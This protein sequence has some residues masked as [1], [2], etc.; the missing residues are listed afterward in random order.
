MKID[1]NGAY[2]AYAKSS[3]TLPQPG[4]KAP[5]KGSRTLSATTD[6]VSISSAA[7]QHS[8]LDKLS[9]GIAAEADGA[10][11]PERLAALRQAVQSGD[12]N[13][14]TEK[15]AEALLNAYV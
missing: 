3:T 8:E 1:L 10:V 4:E 7:A 2:R 13:I 5:G 12:Y 9:H 15:L 14:P 6:R 11:A